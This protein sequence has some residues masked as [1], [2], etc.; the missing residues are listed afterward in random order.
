MLLSPSLPIF[1]TTVRRKDDSMITVLIAAALYVAWR[2][3]QS[4]SDTLRSL[5]RRNDDMIF[6]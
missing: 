6:F 1:R 3:G 2:V 4:L 5:P